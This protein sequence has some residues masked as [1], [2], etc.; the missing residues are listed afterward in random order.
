MKFGSPNIK[1]HVVFECI[2]YEGDYMRGIYMS[3]KEAELRKKEVEKELFDMWGPADGLM[4]EIKEIKVGVPLE[5][6]HPF[7][8]SSGTLHI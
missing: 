3:S 4:V 8:L 2:P 7:T 1:V 6:D 5:N